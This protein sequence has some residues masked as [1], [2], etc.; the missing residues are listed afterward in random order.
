MMNFDAIKTFSIAVGILNKDGTLASE[1]KPISRDVE[2]HVFRA[3]FEGSLE[4]YMAD[5]F[6]GL[7]GALDGMLHE[8][9]RSSKQGAP[10]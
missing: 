5:T 2:Y 4:A 6:E 3:A 8:A 9:E 7:L 1:Y 10:A